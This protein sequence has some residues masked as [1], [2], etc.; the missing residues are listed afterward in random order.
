[1][2][3]EA[4]KA[5]RMALKMSQKEFAKTLGTTNTSVCRWESGVA[6]PRKIYIQEIKRLL[7]KN[8]PKT[9]GSQKNEVPRGLLD[10]PLDRLNIP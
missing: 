5:A 10:M 1:V 8:G 4:I 6:V 9:N 3:N 7:G 2:N